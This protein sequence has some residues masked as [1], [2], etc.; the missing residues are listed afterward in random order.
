MDPRRREAEVLTREEEIALS[1]LRPLVERHLD[2]ILET[3]ALRLCSDPLAA[4]LL[5]DDLAVDRLKQ[6]QQQYL[7]S[8]LSN[9][10][11]ERT[12]LCGAT[13]TSYRDPFGLGAQW[14]LRTL[15]HFVTSL[16]PLALEFLKER[17]PLYRTA[18][19]ALLKVVCRDLDLVMGACL[20][21]RDEWVESA[22]QD[23]CQ[24]RRVLDYILDQHEAEADRHLV[25][26]LKLMEELALWRANVAG[27]AHEMGTPLNVI[28]GHAES[29]VR[30]TG[31]PT[32]QA[33]LHSIV[34]QV[35]RMILLRRSLCMCDGKTGNRPTVSD[36]MSV[37]GRA[38]G[39][40]QGVTGD[41]NGE[42]Q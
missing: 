1:L 34:K 41:R 27:L 20:R 30:E 8:L 22:R 16:Q 17:L 14:H 32:V 6:A 19:N 24:A 7:L 29:L 42:F 3:F 40:D 12:R 26:H 10:P 35:E 2:F 28:L 23:E 4:S 5:E 15:T 33:A 9:E 21:Q 36:G 39:A 11:P 31:D 13:K 37:R 38:S 25:S 18:W